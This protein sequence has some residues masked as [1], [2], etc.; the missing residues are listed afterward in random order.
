M[1][2][3]LPD[4]VVL[5]MDPA[6]V[7]ELVDVVVITKFGSK[8]WHS[9][10]KAVFMLAPQQSP[11]SKSQSGVLFGSSQSPSFAQDGL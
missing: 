4:G 1:K 5:L 7:V 10:Q 2:C 3:Q 9:S 8:H 6:V 11:P